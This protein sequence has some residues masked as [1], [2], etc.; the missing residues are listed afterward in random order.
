MPTHRQAERTRERIIEATYQGILEY[1]IAGATTKRIAKLAGCSEALLYKHFS[2]KEE[3]FLAVIL[4]HMPALA[5]SLRRLQ[6]S[7][8]QGDLLA[9]VTEFAGAAIAFYTG[10]APIGSGIIGDPALLATFRGMLASQD[11]GPHLPI[12]VLASILRAERSG[13]RLAPEADCDAL[14]SLLMGAC[15]HRG[16]MAH[17]VELPQPPEDYARAIVRALLGPITR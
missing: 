15:Y 13:G 17:F 9:N 1:G 4:E 5:P 11:V 3:L 10:S 8:G 16:H 14:A 12:R 2:G 6:V 7:T